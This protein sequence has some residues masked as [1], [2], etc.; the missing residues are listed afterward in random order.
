MHRVIEKKKLG[1]EKKR[2][3]FMANK[4][5]FVW[6]EKDLPNKNILWQMGNAL[7]VEKKQRKK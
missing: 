6:D 1:E 7:Q 5:V 4:G 3:Y 2:K